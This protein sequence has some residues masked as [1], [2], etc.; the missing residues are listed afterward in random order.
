MDL[1]AQTQ[2]PP[3]QPPVNPVVEQTQPQPIIQPQPPVQ[4][5]PVPPGGSKK[6]LMILL[7]VLLLV[8]LGVGGFFAY[9]YFTKSQTYNAGVYTYPTTAPTT[10]TP[11]EVINPN[12]TTDAAL[13]S[14]TKN[15]DEQLNSLNSDVNSVDESINDKQ[16]NL[17]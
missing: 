11:T 16:T 15:V 7:V 17:Q 9:S 3:V 2:T 12:D 14:D 10:P 8:V 13:D 6:G 1:N 5:Q 4:P